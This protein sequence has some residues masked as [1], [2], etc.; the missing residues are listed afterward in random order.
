MT[1]DEIAQI[2]KLLEELMDRAQAR[3]LNEVVGHLEAA[4]EAADEAAMAAE[5]DDSYSDDDYDDS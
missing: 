1:D 2:M 5:N 3:G 4:I